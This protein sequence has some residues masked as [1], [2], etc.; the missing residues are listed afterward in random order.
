[1]PRYLTPLR[2]ST[3]AVASVL[4]IPSIAA[5]QTLLGSA[6]LT[7]TSAPTS[8]NFVSATALDGMFESRGLSGDLRVLILS[9]ED[10][11]GPVLSGAVQHRW[12]RIFAAPAGLLGA[13][14]FA[15][16]PVRPPTVPGVWRLEL[17]G[18]GQTVGDLA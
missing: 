14:A 4:L 7:P 16:A 8:E 6:T 15:H 9:P 13:P 5:S 17:S 2:V 18:A 3:A 10:A 11:V 1:M 12:E